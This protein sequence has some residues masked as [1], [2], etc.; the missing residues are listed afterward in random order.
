MLLGSTCPDRHHCPSVHRRDLFVCVCVCVCVWVCGVG[1]GIRLLLHLEVHVHVCNSIQM[2]VHQLVPYSPSLSLSLTS[3]GP[4]NDVL[5][6]G[7]GGQFKELLT[8]RVAL[9][10]TTHH[11]I[12]Q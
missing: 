7:G 3:H 5:W 1:G 9:V 11:A 2:S 4:C 8:F 6:V 12:E 10:H